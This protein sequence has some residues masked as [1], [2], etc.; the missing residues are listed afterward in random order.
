MYS[1]RRSNPE[2]RELEFEDYRY[3]KRDR[4]ETGIQTLPPVSISNSQH[5][6]HLPNLHFNTESQRATAWLKLT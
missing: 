3:V 1:E 5:S 2:T 6:I 4:V